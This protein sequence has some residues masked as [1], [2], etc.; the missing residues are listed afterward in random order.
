MKKSKYYTP[1]ISEIHQGFRFE[2]QLHNSWK[3]VDLEHIECF[4]DYCCNIEELRVKYLDRED[5]EELGWIRDPED[6]RAEHTAFSMPNGDHLSLYFSE[7]DYEVVIVNMIPKNGFA[8]DLTDF[9]GTIKTI[10]NF[11]R[12]TK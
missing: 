8:N 2:Y 5:I 6:D 1:D 3:Q 11:R 9:C 10:M 4:Y 7:S 12:F